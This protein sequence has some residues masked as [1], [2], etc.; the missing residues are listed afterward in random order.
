M[1]DDGQLL[2]QYTRER[3]ESAFGELVSRHVDLVYSAAVRVAGG[4]RHLAQDVTQGVFMDLARKA[5]RLPRDVLLAGW[6]YRHT[7][8]VA[9]NAVR[10]E[11]RRKTREQVAMEMT[12][13]DDNTE[14]PWEQIAPHLD[15]GLNQ[16]S[17]MDRDAIVLRFLKRQ[18]LR[19]VGAALGISEDAAQKRVSRALE[20][21][22]G[23]LSRRGAALTATGLASV[24]TAEAMT[25]APAGLAVSATAAS[26]AAAA[27]TGTALTL[28]KLMATTKLKT[29]LAGA[30]VVTSV[31]TPLLVQ[32]R[33]H[34]RLRDQDEGLRQRAVRL[35]NLSVENQQLSNL[36]AQANGSPSL[37]KDQLS[38]LFRLRGEVGRLQKD[39]QELSQAKTAAP[40]SRTDSLAS[41]AE[42]YSE[43][44]RRLKELLETNPSEK[45]PELQFLAESD[46]LWLAGRN[47]PDTEDGHR[48]AMR[49]ARL[50]A[51]LIFVTDL[52]DPALKRYVRDNN[53]RFP[54]EISQ[55]KSYF[56]TPVDDAVLERWVVLHKDRLRSELQTRLDEDWY[57]TQKA[58]VDAT[59]DKRILRGLK[60]MHM[61]GY[62]PADMGET[63]H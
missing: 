32:Q 40:L 12:A 34:A 27:G 43:Q 1:T 29:G 19:T 58:P 8:L 53:G 36:L 56:K 7:C 35:A 21:L 46:W 47:V 51:E 45:I 20:K 60:R 30:I 41:M 52:L 42:F 15:E 26:L 37:S 62:G 10:T 31:V 33:A 13:L 18:D 16:L 23:V 3:S 11:R 57:I 14:P 22:R 4:D 17:V 6:L 59:Q 2:Q 28:L 61:P 38:E 44:V 63:V 48:L 39:V 9:A 24:L 49:M 50:K 55:L 5:S 25:A 54:S